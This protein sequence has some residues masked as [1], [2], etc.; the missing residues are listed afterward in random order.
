M[1]M[2]TLIV[3]LK[4]L[5]T[6]YRDTAKSQEVFDCLPTA[7]DPAEVWALEGQTALYYERRHIFHITIS[8]IR[9]HQDG[10]L[11][12]ATPIK[13]PG[14]IIH[15][16]P[17]DF[18]CAWEYLRSKTHR[19]CTYGYVSWD[20]FTDP[21][22]IEQVLAI[23]AEMPAGQTYMDDYIPLPPNTKSLRDKVP[24]PVSKRLYELLR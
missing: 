5:Y 14:L 22:L 19:V 3:R 12:T 7:A 8:N 18:G 16:T 1:S 17:F 9:E 13:T 6:R 10:F 15:D 24:G 11:A 21:V 23:A 4:S 2:C 20:I